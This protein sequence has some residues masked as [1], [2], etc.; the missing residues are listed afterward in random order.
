M[1]FNM[2]RSKFNLLF[3]IA[4]TSF[5]LQPSFVVMSTNKGGSNGD[6]FMSSGEMNKVFLM[7]QEMVNHLV[8]IFVIDGWNIIIKDGW[9]FP[10][11]KQNPKFCIYF[12][13]S[14]NSIGNVIIAFGW[15]KM[16]EWK[17]SKIL[18]YI[19]GSRSVPVII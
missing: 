16:C 2:T 8:L 5:L 11:A 14:F 9:Y 4:C 1:N 6:V 12:W 19:D 18:W 13:P 7:E 17:W 15:L 3:F 10:A